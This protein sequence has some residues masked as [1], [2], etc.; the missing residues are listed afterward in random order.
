MSASNSSVSGTVQS[1]PTS[2]TGEARVRLRNTRHNLSANCISPERPASRRFRA[3]T[4]T[5]ARKRGGSPT[6]GWGGGGTMVPIPSWLPFP[7]PTLGPG[8]GGVQRRL[9]RGTPPPHTSC[10]LTRAHPW[11]SRRPPPSSP[12][13]PLRRSGLF[14]GPHM[15][16]EAL[17]FSQGE[18]A[19]HAYI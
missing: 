9:L 19:T 13:L 16:M 8:R 1:S 2:Q 18:T 3:E 12:P 7:K 14:Q 11:V 15:M 4:P 6:R 10:P 5:A 17:S